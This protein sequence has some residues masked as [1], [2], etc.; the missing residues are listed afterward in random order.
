MVDHANAIAAPQ[1]VSKDHNKKLPLILLALTS[2]SYPITLEV[3]YRVIGDA[4]TGSA[5]HAVA[6]I[7]ALGSA[8]LVPVIGFLTIL[9]FGA[10]V[11]PSPDELATR[12]LA[13]F[14][15]ASPPLYTAL[16][17][18]LFIAELARWD[19][20][21]W[22]L[23]WAAALAA[24][25]IA[26]L[27]P[28]NP[29]VDTRREPATWLRWSHGLVAAIVL[30]GFIG[31]HLGNHLLALKGSELHGQVQSVLRLWYRG[32]IV[33]PILIG[34]LVWLIGSGLILLSYR[35][36]LFADG[37]GS[38]QTASGAYVGAFLISHLAA[39]LVMARMKYGVDTNW[40]WATG[41]PVGLLGD[42]WNVRLI[43]HYL[44][45]VIAV[46]A[47]AVCGLRVVLLG[48]GI[49]HRQVDTITQPLIGLGVLLALVLIPVLLGFRL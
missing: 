28:S 40:D 33:E 7:L 1:R 18:L 38:L 11:R 43:P 9:H 36:R 3:F 19:M 26:R 2:L 29:Q 34:L 17:V 14:V 47:H 48:H 8:L 5:F 20:A 27:P 12:R 25:M 31:L 10:I 15:V 13:H 46:S 21:V 35:T 23:A 30:V 39:S 4:V 41:M 22:L 42:P 6:A 49:D 24:I 16:G 44:F 37:W 45:A 32:P